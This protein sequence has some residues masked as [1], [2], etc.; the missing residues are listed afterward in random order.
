MCELCGALGDIMKY[1]FYCKNCGDTFM[2]DDKE[3]V[4]EYRKNHLVI[5][6]TLMQTFEHCRLAKT[7]RKTFARPS[8]AIL[9]NAEE[10]EKAS[11]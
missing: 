2:S 8:L 1:S 4:K 9:I 11:A 5:F 7:A 6:K 3:K 10:A